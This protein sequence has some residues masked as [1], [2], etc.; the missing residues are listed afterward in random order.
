MPSEKV[1]DLSY[2][3]INITRS[4]PGKFTPTDTKK[5][6]PSEETVAGAVCS[7][8]KKTNKTLKTSIVICSES[9]APKADNGAKWVSVSYRIDGFKE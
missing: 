2:L 3:L 1:G 6:V 4:T 7:Q 9:Q 8:M 5:Y